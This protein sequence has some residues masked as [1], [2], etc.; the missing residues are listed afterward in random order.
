[1]PALYP[2][3]PWTLKGSAVLMLQWIDLARARQFVPLNLVEPVPVGFPGKTLAI[4]YLSAYG[5]GSVLEYSELI[6]APALVRRRQARAGEPLAPWISHIYVDSDRSVAGG[7]DI[8]GL[9]KELA[10]F[11]WREGGVTVSQG[12]RRLCDWSW[13]SLGPGVSLP[14]RSRWQRPCFGRQGD[15][16][17]RFS[18]R[19]ETDIEFLSAQL[20]VPK[21][22][23]FAPLGLKA[24]GLAV[25][26]DRL[27]LLAGVPS[28]LGEPPAVAAARRPRAQSPK[29]GP[30]AKP[31]NPST[32]R[33]RSG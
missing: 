23:P 1:M 24:R 33:S 28:P 31:V 5:D 2:P 32:S 25:E 7:R 22:S 15:R 10:A 4:A 18:A 29:A 17:L 16:L 3:A 8:W 30:I 6:V 26:L 21:E 14:W 19:A 11:S 13:N 27:Y 9:P 12:R 20:T